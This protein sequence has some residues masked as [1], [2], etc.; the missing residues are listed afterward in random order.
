[1]SDK[2]ASSEASRQITIER[3]Y[4]ASIEDVWALWTTKEGIE[5]WWAPD[6]F[7]VEVKQL[8]LRPGGELVYEMTATAPEQIEFMKN[9]GIPTTTESRKTYTEVVPPERLAYMSLA[10]FIP[11][12]EP[13]EF[14]TVVDLHASAGTVRA[15]MKVDRMHDEGW[16]ERLVEG[17]ENELDNL[18]KVI[19]ARAS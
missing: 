14:A 13:Y 7:T 8:D 2:A 12:V 9:E 5:A 19:A 1:M 3:T 4:D 6:G 10:D 18:A 15:V 11:G 16:T 17:R